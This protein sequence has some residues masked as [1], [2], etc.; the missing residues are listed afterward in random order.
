MK[1]TFI[2]IGVVL[3]LIFAFGGSAYADNEAAELTADYISTPSVSNLSIS[4][5]PHKT[6]YGAFELFD[7]TGLTLRASFIDGTERIISAEEIKVSY[8]RDNCFRVGDDS[9]TLSYGGKSIFLP[10]TVNR[11]PY[12]LGGLELDSF[13]TVYNGAFQ[14]YNRPHSQVVGLDGIP[15]V[16]KTSG[17]GINAG[18]YDISIDFHTDSRDYLVPESRV[19]QMTVEPCKA[20]IVWDSLSF[21]YDGRSKS[22]TA[23]YLDVTGSRVYPAVSGAATN[24][25]DSYQARA[26]IKD[27]N[28]TFSNTSVSFEIKKADY[29]FSGVVWSKDS[30]TYDGS[31]KSI[32]A[33]GFPSGVSVVGYTGDR[34]SEAGIY[35]ATAMLLWD[36][37]N[38]NTPPAITHSWEIKKADYNMSGVSFVNKSYVFDGKIHYPELIGSMPV[39]ADGI[40]LEYSFSSGA[41]H[42]SD[43][44]VS[45]VI[46]F[47]TAS[48]NY[49]LPEDRH[50]GVNITPLGIDVVWG[51][52]SLG[53]NGEQQHPTAYSKECMI[54]VSGGATKAG[55]YFATA[56]AESDDY[57][58]RNNRIEYS[59]LKAQNFWSVS[60]ADSVCYE[61]RDIKLIGESR[62]GSLEIKYYEDPEC[63][64]EIKTPTECGI[65][66]AVLTVEDTADYSG[67]TSS[68]ISFEI[69]EILP[70]SFLAGIVKEN[71]KAFDKLREN[72]FVCSV[73][74]NDGSVTVVDSSLVSVEYQ[75]GNSFRKKDTEIKL[76]YG[77]FT[78]TLPVEVGYADYDLSGIKWTDTT[79]VYSGDA[80]YPTLSGLPLG[81][82]VIGYSFNNLINAGRYAVYAELDYDKENY[83]PPEISPCDFIIE[84]CPIEIPTITVTYNGWAQKPVATS[85]NYKI[86]E[87]REYKNAG[88]YPVL[89]K[90]SDPSNYVFRENGGDSA[91]AIF[92]IEPATISIEVLDVNLKLFEEL[93]MADYR[94][95]FGEVYDGDVISVSAYREG[96]QVLLRS[97]NPNYTFDVTPGKINRL[98]YPT[99]EGGLIIFLCLVGL[100]LLI[101]FCMILF[102][103]RQKLLC[104]AGMLKCRWHNRYYKADPPR[105]IVKSDLRYDLNSFSSASVDAD[106]E[107]KPNNDKVDAE[108]REETIST[109]NN[110]E[111]IPKVGFEVDAE[112]ADALISDSLA[113][114]L[115]KREGEMIFTSGS[116]R[117]IVN[118]DTLSKNFS[119]EDKIDVNSLK[120]KGILL[121]EVAYYK[122]LAGGKIDKPLTIYANDFSLTAVK[123]IALTGGQA[124]KILT[125]KDK[126]K[127]EKG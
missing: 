50:A 107:E 84:K 66:Y 81:V 56:T 58:I 126:S 78:L 63:K 91:Y 5:Y 62:F 53:Y 117:A 54:T 103:N 67:L 10:V 64:R 42:V 11:V 104:A 83:N 9:V 30:F 29:D 113:K 82:S 96:N 3:I 26:N 77:K 27:P 121:P 19:I 111:E 109:E 70:V 116:E 60:P 110:E 115:V 20:E 37:T 97:E 23:Y 93:S 75:N 51:E 102:K 122:V 44:V 39:G 2:A 101:L 4:S 28:Y 45:V 40:R 86:T 8:S 89:V 35:N 7:P 22:P 73:L 76:K 33:S 36:E 72:D 47:T 71:I 14:G 41:I 85:G 118:I 87:E 52:T 98:P 18:V 106:T 127:E 100:I 68:V 32:S 13:T 57:Y 38:Y 6:V 43:G 24:A 125:F 16:I 94:I 21:V 17:G 25:G 46:S 34:G 1:K 55:K 74:N 105:Q 112:K 99:F 80:K 95:L 69:V 119:P 61:G 79:Q 48:K 114:S 88:A 12:D 92:R 108:E 15:L 59:I 124:I 90:L 120:E 31:K 49:N 123:M 65:Y